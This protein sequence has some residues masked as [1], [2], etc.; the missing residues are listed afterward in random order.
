MVNE[1]ALGSEAVL[2]MQRMRVIYSQSLSGVKHRHDGGGDGWTVVRN[3]SENGLM[4]RGV[5]DVIA[6]ELEQ[7][8][9]RIFDKP[10]C[11]KTLSL[12]CAEEGA[13]R[14]GGKGHF[15]FKYLARARV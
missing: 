11:S 13:A 9:I 2:M 8:L 10:L 15:N 7:L 6:L 3:Q 5:D 14:R 1:R 4:F 12:L